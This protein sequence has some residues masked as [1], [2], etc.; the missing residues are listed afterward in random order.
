M[1][2]VSVLGASSLDTF[3]LNS[4]DQPLAASP[5]PSTT[6]L[7]FGFAF[8]LRNRLVVS[9]L[10]DPM[11]TGNT[12]VYDSSSS[13]NLT[14]V[15]TQPSQGAAPCWVA[16]TKNGRY[17]FVVNTGG[18]A[19]AT[20]TRY[21]L[22]DDGKLTFLGLTAPNGAEFARTDE[23]LSGDSRYLYVLAPSVKAGDTSKIDEYKVGTD[24]SLSLIGATPSKLPVG[25]SGLDGR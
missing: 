6:P 15:D 3:V 4:A 8:D 20:I 5:H 9:Q 13:G 2:V 16:I 14:P 22:G 17:V 7:P 19:P 21:S 11:G 18:G 24:G 10:T 12:G 25:A 1:L 23:V